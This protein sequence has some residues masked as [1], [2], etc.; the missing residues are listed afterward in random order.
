MFAIVICFLIF[1]I[2]PWQW[3][4]W[5][6][7]MVKPTRSITVVGSA[8]GNF[9]NQ[10]ATYYAGAEAVGPNKEQVVAQVNEQMELALAQ[11]LEF[12][13]AEADIQTSNVSVYQ[14]TYSDGARQGEWRASNSITLTL[15]DISRASELSDLLATTGL[16]NV[17]GP[18]FSLSEDSQIPAALVADA[19][20]NAR[21]RAQA[22]AQA[23]SFKLGKVLDIQEGTTAPNMGYR[24]MDGLGGGGG[25]P[26]MPGQATL[27]ATATVTFEIR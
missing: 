11:L 9:Q 2:L 1:L 3:I 5:G 13:L 17:S 26:V 7:I 22:I 25:A 16:T 8:T 12:G 6:A 18:I 19:V 14:D 27:T 4:N 20:G 10:I 15:R 23:E 21:E 24:M